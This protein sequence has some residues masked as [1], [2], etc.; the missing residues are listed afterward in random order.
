MVSGNQYGLSS[1]HYNN[2]SAADGSIYNRR[3][4][5]K[6]WFQKVNFTRNREAVLWIHSPQHVVLDDAPLAEVSLFYGFLFFEN[7]IP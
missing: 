7:L 6:I 4:L 3:S 5:E 1:V 2:L